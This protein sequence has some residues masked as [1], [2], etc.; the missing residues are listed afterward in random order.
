MCWNQHISMNTFS[1]SV[2]VL[3]LIYFNQISNSPYKIHEFENPLMYLFVM[4]IVMMQLIEYFLWRNMSN[5]SMNYWL[6]L[7]GV[8]LLAFQPIASTLLIPDRSLRNKLLLMYTLPVLGYLLYMV[9]HKKFRTSVSLDGHMK[10][11]WAY[12]KN[13]IL[14]MLGYLFFLYYPLIVTRNVVG[15]IFT[16]SLFVSYYYFYY[17][18]GSAGSLWC[19]SINAMMIYFVI[20]LLFYLPYQKKLGFC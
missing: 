4:S 1:F 16:L 3:L 9:I 13:I 11:N 6:S 20:K 15:F 5:R 14:V 17:R 12:R 7:A 10:W 18:D 8:L 19:W 2:F